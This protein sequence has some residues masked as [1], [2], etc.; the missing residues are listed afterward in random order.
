MFQKLKG[1]LFGASG[2]S[3]P[4]P[5]SGE[6]VPLSAV[7]DPTFGEGLLGKG[8]AIRPTEGRVVAPVDASVGMMFETGHAVTLLTADNAEL[9][10]HIGLD[11]VNLKGKHYTAH[12]KTGDTVKAG[13][14]L[15]E[16]DMA[17][18][19]A[20]GYDTITPIV[21]CNSGD[22]SEVAA[23]T[24]RAVSPLDPLLTLTK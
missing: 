1:K 8:A 10:I 6:V 24:G 23:L 19:K 12:V 14:L 21:I 18:I 17:A 2:I 7:S 11:T 22:F 13:D 15:I 20:E 4:A 9:L 16:F 5:L 3:I